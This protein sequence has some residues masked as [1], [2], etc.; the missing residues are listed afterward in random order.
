MHVIL[1][2]TPQLW[3]TSHLIMAPTTTRI[4]Y[5]SKLCFHTMPLPIPSNTFWTKTIRC[6]LYTTFSHVAKLQFRL[7]SKYTVEALCTVRNRNINIEEIVHN[8]YVVRTSRDHWMCCSSV[9]LSKFRS[10]TLLHC[11]RKVWLRVWIWYTAVEY[12]CLLTV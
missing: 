3:H 10:G 8:N 6:I 5:G 11:S 12:I 4:H 2:H 1:H 7:S 9:V